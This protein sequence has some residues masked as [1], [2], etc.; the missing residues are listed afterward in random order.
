[1]GAA[2]GVLEVV[3]VGV[4]EVA[5]AA[6]EVGLGRGVSTGAGLGSLEHP[7]RTTARRVATVSA[8]RRRKRDWCVISIVTPA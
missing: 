4:L 1:M 6:V 7:T 8:E 2:V 3:A 5:S